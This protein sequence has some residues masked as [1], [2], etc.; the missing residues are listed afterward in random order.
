MATS[1]VFANS[2]HGG[3]GT[4]GRYGAKVGV[5]P[6]GRLNYNFRPLKT[7]YSKVHS[8]ISDFSRAL[9]TIHKPQLIGGL[10]ERQFH[11]MAAAL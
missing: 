10:T 11:A 9:R 4:D 5:H 6:N 3:P 7:E 2:S 1:D 8:E